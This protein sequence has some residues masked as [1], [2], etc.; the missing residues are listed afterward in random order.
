MFSLHPACKLSEVIKCDRRSDLVS[1]YVSHVPALFGVFTWLSGWICEAIRPEP[2]P[3]HTA[4]TVNP[5]GSQCRGA[6]GAVFIR[7]QAVTVHLASF[8]SFQN[9]VQCLELQPPPYLFQIP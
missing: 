7:A 8:F 9:T 2:L 5:A 1:E 3:L 4:T 6:H